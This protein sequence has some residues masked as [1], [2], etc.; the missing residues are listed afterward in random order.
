MYLGS[1]LNHKEHGTKEHGEART[2]GRPRIHHS[3]TSSRE[4]DIAVVI[5]VLKNKARYHLSSKGQDHKVK[6]GL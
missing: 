2:K 4:G 5:V 3:A 1:G 6:T